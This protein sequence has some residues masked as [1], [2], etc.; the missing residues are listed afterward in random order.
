MRVRGSH[1]LKIS[2]VRVGG[3]DHHSLYR[4]YQWPSVCRIHS[5]S[6]ASFI[7]QQ[8]DVPL[9]EDIGSE[10]EPPFPSHFQVAFHQL[11][12]YLVLTYLKKKVL[13]DTVITRQF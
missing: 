10:V 2:S 11:G 7:K 1:L 4:L 6:F 3:I 5:N 8:A 9:V 12:G 13:M